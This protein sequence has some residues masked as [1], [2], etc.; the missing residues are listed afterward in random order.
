MEDKKA[1]L[2]EKIVTIII[3]KIH[4]SE[5]IGTTNFSVLLTNKLNMDYLFLS[6]LFS[7]T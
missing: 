1:I 2:V 3:D 5:E 6:E 4:N 7:K